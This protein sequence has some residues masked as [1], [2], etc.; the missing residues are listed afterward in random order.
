[1]EYRP[2]GNTRLKVSEIGSGCGNVGGLMIR[3]EHGDQVQAVARAMEMGINYFDSHAADSAVLL[4]IRIPTVQ[5]PADVKECQALPGKTDRRARRTHGPHHPGRRRALR[6]A[7]VHRIRADRPRGRYCS[8]LR[9]ERGN[10]SAPEMIVPAER[11][12]WPKCPGERLCTGLGSRRFT[13]PPPT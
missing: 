4:A 10:W 9:R 13:V 1:M 2:F 7:A 8:V 3:G 12:A 6:V 11:C 5:S